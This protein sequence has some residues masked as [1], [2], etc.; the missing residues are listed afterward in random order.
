MRREPLFGEGAAKIFAK[1][2]A[3]L[4]DLFEFLAPMVA[5]HVTGDA[6]TPCRVCAVTDDVIRVKCNSV[7][8]NGAEPRRDESSSQTLL[9]IAPLLRSSPF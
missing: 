5:D 6:A 3:D 2:V 7:A 9:P 1:A 8:I 4:V